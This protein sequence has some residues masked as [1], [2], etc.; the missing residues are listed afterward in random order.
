M[1][2]RTQTAILSL[3]TLLQ[4][5]LRADVISDWNRTGDLYLTQYAPAPAVFTGWRGLAMMHVA[6][7]DAVNAC[8]GGSVPYAFNIAAQGASAQAAAAQAAYCVLTNISRTNLATLDAALAASLSSVP[9]SSARQAGILLGVAAA[10]AIIQ[11]HAADT[12]GLNVPALSSTVPGHWRPTPPNF[13]AGFGAQGRYLTPW[14]LRSAAQFRPG[15]P[16]SSTSALYATDYNEVRVLGSRIGTNRTPAQIDSAQLQE[17]GEDWLN[18]VLTNHP[19]PLV[20]SARRAALVYMCAMDALI[21]VF[22]AKHTYN[23]W[24]PVSAIRSGSLDGNDATA[25]DDSWTPFL[26]TH[27]HPEYPSLL[28]CLTAALTESLSLFH[29]EDFGF[30]AVSPGKT[31]RFDRLS[32]YVDDATTARI[33]GGTH[34]RNSCDVA[35]LLGRQIARNAFQNFLRPLPSLGGPT[36]SGSEIQL[37]LQYGAPLAFV[38]EASSDLTQ[39][40]PWKTNFYGTIFESVLTGGTDHQFYRAVAR[41]Q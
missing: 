13:S 8:I 39:W 11:L 19:L 35:A 17:T 29:N 4:T 31:R 6:Q 23:F 18:G 37:H 32:D 10:D 1:K 41:S 5:T 14:T 12:P 7:F 30:D 16:P 27:R 9:E 22:D 2:I 21:A 38:I 26:D 36:G 3:L 25:Q 33:A 34:F 24:R 15:P 20:E 40:T 28:V